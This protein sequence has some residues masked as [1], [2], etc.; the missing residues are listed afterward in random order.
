MFDFKHKRIKSN[1]YIFIGEFEDDNIILSLYQEETGFYIQLEPKEIE[2]L[3]LDDY[4]IFKLIDFRFIFS[5]FVESKDWC[6]QLKTEEE[7]ILKF[8]N[9]LN[10][11]T[12]SYNLVVK[13]ELNAKRNT[14]I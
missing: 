14:R 3:I 2:A 9:T 11:Y 13:E 1:D 5:D 10:I 7:A 12:L 4:I 8:L 6:L